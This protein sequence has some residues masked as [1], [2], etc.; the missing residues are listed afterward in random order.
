MTRTTT[1]RRRR[2]TERAEL[3]DASEVLFRAAVAI[4][5]RFA[6]TAGREVERSC[7]S[8]GPYPE[9]LILIEEHL[10]KAQRAID[11]LRRA[12]V[13]ELGDEGDEPYGDIKSEAWTPDSEAR[14]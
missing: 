6:Y 1:T 9:F 2:L 13:E 4:Q 8:P 12:G 10:V 11:T 3:H 7:A 5:E 14:S